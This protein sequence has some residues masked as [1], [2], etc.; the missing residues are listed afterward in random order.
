MYYGDQKNE[1]HFLLLD[2]LQSEARSKEEVMVQ[3]F[4]FC[5]NC[6]CCVWPPPGPHH[7]PAQLHAPRG[8]PYIWRTKCPYFPLP[9][10]GAFY[11]G[12]MAETTSFLALG[13][14]PTPSRHKRRDPSPGTADILCPGQCDVLSSI[15]GLWEH[16]LPLPIV[17]R[18]CRMSPGGQG[19]PIENHCS[20]QTS[21]V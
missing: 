18:H 14:L 19:H 5:L 16:P 13:S 1:V 7:S 4:R 2:P 15:L 17:S 6:P 21:D 11:V 12:A 10:S 9:K 3:W 8:D 20:K